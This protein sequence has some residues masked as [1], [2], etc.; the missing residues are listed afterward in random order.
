MA[1]LQTYLIYACIFIPLIIL[2]II[3]LTKPKNFILGFIVV[4]PIVNIFWSFKIFK[5]S[6]IDIFYGIFPLIFILIYFKMRDKEWIWGKFNKYLLIVLVAYLIPLLRLFLGGE[7]SLSALELFVKILFGYAVYCLAVNLFKH[8]DQEKIVKCILFAVLITNIM[9]VY[10]LVTGIGVDSENVWRMSGLYHDP[11]QYTRMALLGIIILLPSLEFV[12][13]KIHFLYKYG[14][15]MLCIVTLGYSVS[16]NVVL[17]V[18]VVFIACSFFLRKYFLMLI[19]S[20]VVIGFYF[21][22]PKI[23]D[24]YE[25]KFQMEIE[26][27]RGADIPIEKLGSGRIGTWQKTIEVFKEA[28]L[29]EKLF[30]SGKDIGPHGQFFGLLRSVGIFGLIASIFFYLI[31]LRYSYKKFKKDRKNLVAFYSFLIIIATFVMAIGSAP[32]TNYYLQGILFMFIALL[33]YRDRII[34]SQAQNLP[35][36]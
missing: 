30:G 2:I 19:L 13:S 17:S 33:E 31:L 11:G 3:L 28:P 10:Q 32:M 18:V 20:F 21:F 9:V 27:F 15:L 12:K 35:Y 36:L 4:A 14:I 6:I 26:Y 8:G 1:N 25:L 29:L 16:R 7:P 24:R 23:Q 34:D 5:L 22:S